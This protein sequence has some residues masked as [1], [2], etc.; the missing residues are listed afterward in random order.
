MGLLVM[1][2]RLFFL[3]L[4]FTVSSGSAQAEW[5][6]KDWAYRKQISLDSAA[7]TTGGITQ[8]AQNVPVLLRLHTGNFG[9]FLDVQPKGEDLRFI[10]ADGRTPLKYQIEKFDPINEMAFIWVQIPA[11]Q[12]ATP[13]P[14]FYMYYGNA[15]AVSGDDPGGVFDADQTLVYHFDTETP[16]P[17]DATAYA[18]NPTAFTGQ[19]VAEGL[20]A[21]AARFDGS[22]FLKLP[23]TPVLAM[24]AATGWTLSGW[25]RIDQPQENAYLIHRAGEEGQLVLGIDGQS[26]FVRIV[27]AAGT[28]VETARNINLQ[29]GGWHHLAV[30]ASGD[31]LTLY[32]DGREAG[33]IETALPVFTAPITVASASDGS[34]GFVGLLDELEISRVARSPETIALA[35]ISQGPTATLVAYGEDG[36]QEDE[37]GGGEQSY[38][39]I[40][41][42]NVTLDG[43]VVIVFL[44][45]MSAISVVVMA[46]KFMVIGRVRKDN[47]SFLTDFEKLAVNNI[48]TLNSDDIDRTD[49]EET[50]LL[51]ALS[52]R[53]KHYESSTLYRLYHAGV[54]EME[55]RLRRSVGAAAVEIKPMFLSVQAVN[56]IRAT[57]DGRLVREVQRLNNLMVLLTIAIS[58]GP[59]LGLLGT[60]VGVMIT[61]AAIA[62]SGD[63]NVN[64]IAPGIAAALVATVAGLAVAIP[65]LFG[66]NYLGSWI[67]EVTAD[68]QVFVDEFVAKIAEQHS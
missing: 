3:F 47:A 5:W 63:V 65:A 62:A 43:W 42:H 55:G 31:R 11:I 4:F 40:T 52:G 18:S 51:T 48:G 32:V 23:D 68:M 33:F 28:V 6:N 36:S 30:T 50:P 60:V 24:D 20:I 2:F 21:A 9:Y 53:H 19:Q 57:M 56:A 58:G 7:L 59:F 45:I 1:W 44:A 25:V 37:G 39:M 66:Y 38:F 17:R 14:V 49:A 54:Q 26:P 41:L 29:P 22:S 35:A 61:F 67:K 12:P 8:A 13:L 15:Q 46:S 64:S 34:K 16:V 10:L 27:D